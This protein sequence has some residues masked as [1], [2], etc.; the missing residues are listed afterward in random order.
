M[1]TCSDVLN[2]MQQGKDLHYRPVSLVD[3][4]FKTTD[5]LQAFDRVSKGNWGIWTGVL[6][7][8]NM[9]SKKKKSLSR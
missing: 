6:S 7:F 8:L 3:G 5:Q 9:R 2:K 4:E 1:K